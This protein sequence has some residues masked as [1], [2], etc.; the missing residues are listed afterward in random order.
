MLLVAALAAARRAEAP[1]RT[2]ALDAR[3]LEAANRRA[4]DG[5][6]LAARSGDFCC[7]PA[8]AH[9]RATLAGW[10]RSWAPHLRSTAG[11]IADY[12]V[13]RE[14]VRACR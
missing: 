2:E 4:R 14:Q 8:V 1:S 5:A 12:A 9:D 13:L 3:Q 11:L 6:T 10:R 7:P